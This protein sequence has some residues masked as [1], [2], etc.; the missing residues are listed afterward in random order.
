MGYNLLINGIN[1]VYWR[2]NPL[3]S[4][5]LTSWHILIT[6]FRTGRG[7]PCTLIQPARGVLE[8]RVIDSENAPA[9][10]CVVSEGSYPKHSMFVDAYVSLGIQSPSENGNGT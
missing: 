2:Y 3:T 9:F 8:R 4:L 1:G 7:P 6:P 5:L 10:F